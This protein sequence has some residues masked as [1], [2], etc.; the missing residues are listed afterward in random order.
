MTPPPPNPTN[1]LRRSGAVGRARTRLICFPHAGGAASFFSRWARGLPADV[2]VLAVNYPG[3]EDRINEPCI[4]D[5]DRMAEAVTRQL[6]PLLD[7]G[8]TFFG[9][10]MGAKIAFEVALRLE[11]EYGREPAALFLSGSEAPGHGER[12]S[13]GDDDA[14]LIEYIATLGHGNTEVY[15]NPQLRELLLPS[16]RSD[17]RLV[18]RYDPPRGR[19]TPTPLTVYIGDRDPDVS[20]EDAES[21]RSATTGGFALKTFPGGHFYLVDAEAALLTELSQRLRDAA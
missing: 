7:D 13:A 2:E 5:M 17:F 15:D 12:D 10:S 4:D 3:R 20:V 11:K 21:W 14:S 18:E 19:S 8:F 16:L 9:H 6:A 1:W